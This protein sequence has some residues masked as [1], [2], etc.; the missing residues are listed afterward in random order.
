M[1]LYGLGRAQAAVR[2]GGGTPAQAP[3]PGLP[4]SGPCAPRAR[5]RTAVCA[6]AS[7]PADDDSV[8]LPS[9]AVNVRRVPASRGQKARAAPCQGWHA[10]VSVTVTVTVA[11]A[12][13]SSGS[14]A[15]RIGVR[16]GRRVSKRASRGSAFS[17]PA[18]P[19]PRRRG[20]RCGRLSP[21]GDG[22]EA[23]EPEPRGRRPVWSLGQAPRKPEGTPCCHIFG[24]CPHTLT[25]DT[26]L[27]T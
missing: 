19:G 23:R 26:G 15:A 6:P 8:V 17:P 11:T 9:R 14:A 10:G 3:R 4:P 22:P 1:A 7:P 2:R 25:S 12:G 16:G 5:P 18:Q 13:Q 27:F 20:G 24:M 21:G